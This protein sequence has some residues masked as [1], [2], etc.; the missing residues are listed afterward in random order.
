MN[1]SELYEKFKT[2]TSLLLNQNLLTMKIKNHLIGLLL[3][4]FALP[5][6]AQVT[7]R[8][9][10]IPDYTPAGDKIYI[11]GD[12]TEWYLDLAYALQKDQSGQWFITLPAQEAGTRIEYMFSRGSVWYYE[13]EASGLPKVRRQYTFSS[14]PDTVAITIWNWADHAFTATSAA[15]NVTR[16][17]DNFPMPQFGRTRRVWLYLPPGYEESGKDYPVIYMQDGEDVFDAYTSWNG[18]WEVDETLNDLAAKGM[19]VPIV[20]AVDGGWRRNYEYSPWYFTLY[21]IKGQGKQYVDF[22]TNTLKPYVDSAY[23]TRPGPESTCIMGSSLGGLLSFYAAMKRPDVFS[24]AG[25]FSPSYWISDSVWTFVR[26]VEKIHPMRLYQI[27]E[28]EE[29]DDMVDNMVGMH[30]YLSGLGFSEEEIKYK[31]VEGAAHN[32]QFWRSEFKEAFLWLFPDASSSAGKDGY[33][34]DIA[35]YPN[36]AGN[37][38]YIDP[39]LPGTDL[40]VQ[41]YSANGA[42]VIQA[43]KISGNRIQIGTLPTGLYLLRITGREIA[44]SGRFIKK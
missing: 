11:L 22:L 20:V 6:Q 40:T 36:P 3:V 15:Q 13:R 12:F 34:T 28:T 10:T 32:V 7:F 37:T 30:D 43:R 4:A 44:W 14:T 41:V 2:V 25:I 5:L 23:R 17:S 8:V 18:E 31:I 16:I 27:V 26:D 21:G 9:D 1:S 24:K 38:L 42:S 19:D 29:G 33:L 39:P 35:V